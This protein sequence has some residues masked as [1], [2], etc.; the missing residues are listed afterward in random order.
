[1][2]L[3]ATSQA[4]PH[5]HRKPGVTP[6]VLGHG[7]AALLL[8]AAGLG[9]CAQGTPAAASA[10]TSAATSA[11]A[12]A[13]APAAPVPDAATVAR[14]QAQIETQL[15]GGE[16]AAALALAERAVALLPQHAALQFLRGVALMDLGRDAQALAHFQWFSANWPELPDPLNNIA[17][18]HARAGRLE[19]ALQALQDA[20]RADPA[21]HAARVNLGHVHLALAVRAW[22]TAAVSAALE[23]VLA[24]R[25]Q[26]ARD[27]LGPPGR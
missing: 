17:L 12:M 20:L 13:A 1:M 4:A 11:V 18:L 3:S 24:Q 26:A 8:G 2:P 23:P 7:L 27:L 15:R 19:Q 22:E 25:L 5:A 9:A 6:R 21:H 16:A 10:A 14:V